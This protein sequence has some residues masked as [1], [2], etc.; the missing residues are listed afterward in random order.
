MSEKEIVKLF[1]NARFKARSDTLENWDREN[2]ILLSGE[3]GIAI[4]V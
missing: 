4:S 3:P 2:P 1:A